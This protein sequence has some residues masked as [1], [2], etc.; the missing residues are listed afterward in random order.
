MFFKKKTKKTKIAK[1]TNN[2]NKQYR[3][4]VKNKLNRERNYRFDKS[5]VSIKLTTF[6]GELITY[7]KPKYSYVYNGVPGGWYV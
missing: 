6:G 4:F 5:R 7:I 3:K 2:N 1:N